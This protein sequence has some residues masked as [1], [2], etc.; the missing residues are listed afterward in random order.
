MEL[1]EMYLFENFW[2]L[3]IG[4]VVQTILYCP[5][6]N[7]H[8][9][10]NGKKCKQQLCLHF[11]RTGIVFFLSL[12]GPCWYLWEISWNFAVAQNALI[13]RNT[14][15]EFMTKWS[16]ALMLQLNHIDACFKRNSTYCYTNFLSPIGCFD[17]TERYRSKACFIDSDNILKSVPK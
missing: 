9:W 8:S 10:W 4:F 15:I 1:K 5:L 17:V 16:V 13:H 6:P 7:F 11:S 2:S 12:S 3:W 14:K